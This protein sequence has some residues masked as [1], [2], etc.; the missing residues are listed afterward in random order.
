MHRIFTGF[1]CLLVAV[2]TWA[3]SPTV[4][5]SN[6]SY[7]NIEGNR[8]NFR[9]TS[10]NGAT[11]IVV[12]KKGSPVTGVPVN[13]MD[14]TANSAFGTPAALFT[15]PDEYVVY[16]GTGN[17]GSITN[18][19]PASTYYLA[20]FEFNGSGV[21]T[22]YL[23]VP[24]TGSESTRSA[25]TV[26][27]SNIQFSQI[28]G[29]S[30]RIS[31]TAGNG[32]GR[33]VVGRKGGPVNGL[34]NNLQT[35]SFS[36]DFGAGAAINGENYVLF[37]GSGNSV[38]VTGLEPNTT[39]HFSVIER[40]GSSYPVYKIPGTSASV[41]TSAGPT[42]PSGVFTFSNVEGN[43]M[44]VSVNRGNGSRRIVIAKKESAVT[45]L[46]QNGQ[47]YTAN[48]AFGSGQ[49]LA[50][51]E[52][53]VFNSNTVTFT[54]T[55]LE[56]NTVYHFRSIEYDQDSE[57]NTFYFLTPRDVSNS[58]AVTPE[59][60]TT[61]TF[62]NVTGNS[63]TLQYGSGTGGYRTVIGR[64]GAPVS[65]QPQ[66][67]VRY[68][69]NQSFGSGTHMGDGNYVIIGSSNGSG[70]NISNLRPGITYHF[71]V[72]E[73]NG[74]NYPVYSTTANNV[75]I[76][77]PA[78]PLSPAT[79]FSSG[80]TQGNGFRVSWTNGDG[81]RRIVVMKKNS[82]VTAR[83]VDGVTYTASANFG[84]GTE[85]APGEF[86]MYDGVNANVTVQNLEIATTYH[87]AVFEYNTTT[88]GPDYL[89]NI[90]LSGSATTFSA[91]T[92]QVSNLTATTINTTSATFSYVRGNGE[93]QLFIMKQGSP[94]DVEPTDLVSYSSNTIFGTTLLADGNYLVFKGTASTSFTV[95]A[96]QPGTTY[97]VAAF[98]LNGATGPVYARPGHTYSFTTAGV[99]PTPEP[100]V[101]SGN[102]VFSN[103]DGTSIRL[104][105]TVGDGAGQLVVAR[106][107]AP[108]DFNPADGNAYTAN[109]NFGDGA[110]LGNGQ[111]VVFR[112]NQNT[113]NVTGLP[114]ASTIHF[115]VFEYNGSGAAINY[116]NNDYLVASGATAS[117][118]TSKSS[119]VQTVLTESTAQLQWQKGNGDG[120]LIVVRESSPVTGTPSNLTIYPASATF[121]NGSQL[122]VGEY[123]VYA[124][125]GQL[126]NI[127]GLN[128][129]TT[130][131]Y[132]IIEYNGSLAPVYATDYLEGQFT[133]GTPLPV[134]WMYFNANRSAETVLL[135][136]AT[137]ME[138]NNDRFVIERTNAQGVF[139]AI[140]SLNGEGNASQQR[141]Y[142][143]IDR[144][145]PSR[146]VQYRIKQVDIDGRFSYSA[147]VQLQASAT[148]GKLTVYPN[149]AR[150]Q[151][152]V[153]G[154]PVS[155]VSTVTVLDLAGKSVLKTTMKAGESINISKLI[156][157]QYLIRIQNKEATQVLKLV[158]AAN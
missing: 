152:Y 85:I 129:N 40:N 22:E 10:G 139:E 58:T 20:V 13:G 83:P 140:D 123:V 98:G 52:F 62:T 74:V 128:N 136:W 32:E 95:T 53:V 33:I 148:S 44:G 51:G 157:G 50:P 101:A 158:K 90:F 117:A 64:E 150:D 99:A 116:L 65:I 127:T 118:P 76:T 30:V 105:W 131:H 78:Q 16:R 81:S 102:A 77:M 59:P 18:L 25:P 24:G 5:A 79:N 27:A 35:Y 55:E 107:G 21:T 109:A 97:H 114:P 37:S 49:E 124:G 115:A 87:V 137:A 147:I 9:F 126:L 149:P 120:R 122:A 23:L 104:T 132:R 86:V 1:L 108:V 155:E 11:R 63:L 75:Q 38:N 130:Y 125:T 17:S 141:Q 3:A 46:P 6:F 111:F 60:P 80:S 94:V 47:S 67:L 96:L 133:I 31:F 19:E 100:T 89:N 112:G 41:Q 91:P 28:A 103:I 4:P 8:F 70:V 144:N 34:P 135:K 145:A 2:Q 15:T 93:Q 134:S 84:A 36:A 14:Y 57:G 110:S 29:S 42:T 73:H 106:V 113:V 66:D 39:Y 121:K 71:A 68:N 48:A 72:F 119:N 146:S 43:R 138:E 45:S 12:L 153:K 88:A 92:V 82:A 61:V 154:L 142:Q 56:P 156:P 143:Y 151:V 69:G 26:D 7:N 54:L